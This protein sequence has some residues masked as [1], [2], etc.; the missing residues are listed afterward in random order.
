MFK[1]YDERRAVQSVVRRDF[2]QEPLM[3]F[4]GQKHPAHIGQKAAW[5]SKARELVLLA[6][7][8][9]GK[10]SLAPHLG[11]REQQR[12]KF[13]DGLVV[14]PTLKLLER[15]MIPAWLRAIRSGEKD[16]MGSYK[17]QKK[18]IVFNERGCAELGVPPF[19]VWFGHGD[20]QDSLEAMDAAWAILDESGQKRFKSASKEAINRRVSQREG[21]IFHLTTPYEFN[22]LKYDITDTAGKVIAASSSGLE[23]TEYPERNQNI[24]VI[25]FES[26]LNPT[27]PTTEWE[28]QQSIMEP[29]RFKMMYCGQFTRPAGAVLGN[30]D[31]DLHETADGFNVP[32]DWV[33]V[34][35]T[36]FGEVNTAAIWGARMPGTNRW[37]IFDE[38][39][40]GRISIEAHAASFEMR[41]KCQRVGGAPS[42][43][44]WRNKFA[45]AG[46]P[47]MRPPL[48][49]RSVGYQLM[50]SM[51]SENRL[52]IS[53]K[54]K[55]LL[56]Q[57]RNMSYEL[58]ETGEVNPLRIE[59]EAT[60]HLIAALRYFCVLVEGQVEKN[61]D[62]PGSAAGRPLLAT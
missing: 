19:T 60:F 48:K 14:A 18:C 43:D 45:V 58:T 39:H 61:P 27:F 2:E 15:A 12:M 54:C 4:N 21:R 9:S 59:D 29:W 32:L 5:A 1:R 44:E 34:Q 31:E 10:T 55:R 41:G 33:K 49:D 50:N 47:I 42:E 25:S 30:F 40:A 53:K 37:L 17:E 3:D 23:I 38:Y 8:R 22:W 11:L 13:G 51:F 7:T 24:E 56:D 36:D 6:G 57:I 62:A 35:G 20:D 46:C 26:R 28:Y 16:E 52:F